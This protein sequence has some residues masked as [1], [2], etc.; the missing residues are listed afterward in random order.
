[1]IFD[2]MPPSTESIKRRVRVFCYCP[3]AERLMPAAEFL[4]SLP[5]MDLAPRVSDPSDDRLMQMARLDRD[6]HAEHV[7]V[8]AAMTHGDIEFLPAAALGAKGLLDLV[9]APRPP[10]EEWWLLLTGQDP[11]NLGPVI[12]RT[13]AFI[14]RQ[15]VRPFYYAFDEASRSMPCFTD[16]APHLDVLI[17]D[18]SPLAEAGRAAL[19]LHCLTIHRSWVAN[20]LPFAAPFDEHPE[21]K[22]LFLGSKLGFTPHRRRQVEF[23][24]SK[25]KDRIVAIHDHSLPVGERLRLSQFKVGFCPEGRMFTTPG[26]RLTHTDRPFWSGCL[27]MV[28]VSEDSKEGGRL[29]ELHRAGLILRYAHGDHRGLARACE[30]ALAMP[31]DARRRIY[32]YFNKNETVGTVVAAAIHAVGPP[33]ASVPAVRP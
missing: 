3:W 19:G 25:F 23:L 16:V 9:S 27:G 13:L 24:Q 33:S 6:W 30:E 17:H 5:A 31:N 28:P 10:S 15:G 26:M 12:G 14:V 32:D 18:E 1:L 11:R 8:F 29:E 21:E 20:L 4:A 22:I 7:R 2:F